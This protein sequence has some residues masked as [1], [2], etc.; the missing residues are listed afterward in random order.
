MSVI[1]TNKVGWG[2]IKN[3]SQYIDLDYGMLKKICK[4]KD[5]RKKSESDKTISEDYSNVCRNSLIPIP[6]H[7][8]PLDDISSENYAPHS[9]WQGSSGDSWIGK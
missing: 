7:I 5:L 8:D 2:S 4:T 6:G 9:D 3:P 1:I